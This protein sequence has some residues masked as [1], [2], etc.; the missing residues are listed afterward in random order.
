VN[1]THREEPSV[2]P[3]GTTL[4]RHIAGL[5]DNIIAA[6]IVL[7]VVKQIDPD[8]TTLQAVVAVSVY[9][10]YYFILEAATSRTI[11]KLLT[12]L[13]I[14]DFHGG[15]CS[16]KQTIIRTAFR[17]IEVNPF[18]LG[19]L[20]AAIRII[21]SRHK[22]RFGDRVARTMVVFSRNVG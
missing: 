21:W 8:N 9:L 4:A 12:G 14:V 17:L 3:F 11:G 22:Q 7:V 20:P 19:A 13:K 18:L 1:Q 6:V 10:A 16:I 15:R 2:S 5:L